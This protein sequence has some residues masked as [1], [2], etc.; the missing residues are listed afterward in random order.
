L[1]SLRVYALACVLL[2]SSLLLAIGNGVLIEQELNSRIIPTLGSVSADANRPVSIC[3]PTG[4]FSGGHHHG[5]GCPFNFVLTMSQENLTQLRGSSSLLQLSVTLISGISVPLAMSTQG[6]PPG[7]TVLFTPALAKPSFSS[8]ITIA[9]SA[10]TPLGQFNI[11][12]LA[13]G[14]G[15]EKS[16]PLALLV[17]PIV[18]DISIVS[19]TVQ[20]TATIG[21]IVA[22]N[23]TVANDGSLLET[24]E[25]QAYANASLVAN[26]FVVKLSP[27]VSYA[28]RLMWNTSGFSPGIY[29][30]V[31]TMPPVRN[32]LDNSREA[33][34]VTLTQTPASRPSPSPGAPGAGQGLNYGRQLAV[35][36]AIAEVAI[37]FFV[38]LRRKGKSGSESEAGPKKI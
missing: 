27:S 19:A 26:L 15:I 11:T 9:T 1:I 12:I 21:S 36:A 30:V 37:V 33:G 23:A 29:T 35:A 28:G 5:G 17:V 38:V 20:P 24:F 32:E 16:A 2:A 3:A 31:V 4:T 7:T 14:G 25:L 6:V 10:E 22:I 18:H 34:K 13:T 8:T